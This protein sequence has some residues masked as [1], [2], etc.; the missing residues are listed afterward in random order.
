MGQ[1]A[2]YLSATNQRAS[3]NKRIRQD[4]K[5]A[6]IYGPAF[7]VLLGNDLEERDPVDI[8]TFISWFK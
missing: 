3:K 5:S 7:L 1:K 4:R 2:K 8:I 6:M